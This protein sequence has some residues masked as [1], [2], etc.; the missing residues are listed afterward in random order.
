MADLP[1][2]NSAPGDRIGVDTTAIIVIGRNEAANL[3]ACLDSVASLGARC[4]LYVDSGST[5]GSP[6]LAR[7]K[8]VRVIDLAPDRP[9]S[10]ARAR[11]EGAS[12][13]LSDPAVT[14]LHFID[15]DC[16]LHPDWLSAAT[17][18]MDRA[19]P[20][21]AICGMLTERH[22]ERSAY[23]RLCQREWA[24]P[25]GP[26][27]ACGGIALFRAAAFRAAQGFDPT[28]IAGEEPDLCLR[29]RRMGWR[30]ERLDLPMA[31]HDAAMTRFSQFWH[32]SRRAGHAFAEGSW[33]HRHGPERHW[34]RET[35]RALL[36]GATLPA[37]ILALLPVSPTIAALLV[38]AYPAQ[39]LRL[40]ARDG[41]T[42]N[43][44]EA[45]LLLTIAK[46]AEA[47]GALAFHLRRLLGA[48]T[49]RAVAD[50]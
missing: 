13:A 26:T 11:N 30:I 23:N 28:L 12:A 27:D 4:I 3:A 33:R 50:T 2:T 45:A 43:G 41:F 34:Q 24:L 16:R 10:A 20:L 15:G 17:A 48:R 38:L 19:A 21:A 42:R 32:R 36:W 40:A 37:G 6:A 22:P 39:V 29:L 7:A 8:A 31:D 44:I 5:D 1:G 49:D 18:F 35:R 25:P 14:A 46:F 47:Q 9:F